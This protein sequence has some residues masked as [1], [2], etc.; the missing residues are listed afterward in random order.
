MSFPGEGGA[1][2]LPGEGSPA[3]G[4]RP[5]VEWRQAADGSAV[6]VR[7]RLG[8]GDMNSGKEGAR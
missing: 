6:D 4:D 5:Q 3:S 2:R 7:K 8:G 1:M